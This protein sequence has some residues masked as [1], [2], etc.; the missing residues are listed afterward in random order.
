LLV[1]NLTLACGFNPNALR[2]LLSRATLT[3]DTP[4]NAQRYAIGPASAVSG[5]S[6]LT[7]Y[8]ANLVVDFDGVRSGEPV[9]GRIESLTEVTRQPAALHRY[10]K[11]STAIPRVEVAA[12]T[13][14]FFQI[15]DKVYVKKSSV[16]PWLTFQGDQVS[17]ESL[18]FFEVD[19]LIVLPTTV[20]GPPMLETLNGLAVEH[21]VFTESDLDDPN[22]VFTQAQGDVWIAAD[23]DYLMQYVLSATLR[24]VIPD[25][26]ADLFHEGRLSL[27]YSLTDINSD[28]V[29]TPPAAAITQSA[30]FD[31]LPRLPDAQ[32]TSIYPTLLEYTSTISAI[33]ATLFYREALTA[34]EWAEEDIQIFNEKSRLFYSKAGQSLTVII[35]PAE[36]PDKIKVTVDVVDR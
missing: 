30:P 34:Q 14:D 2:G 19:R 20:A 23:D 1:V 26:N 17:P 16:A 22:L 36:T 9:A 27:R 21:Y 33:S 28:F 5:L 8:Q 11:S 4:A 13:A 10:L 15:D 12:G 6:Q 35:T 24:V 18:G 25:P 7:G 29:I 32:I 3:P 31:E